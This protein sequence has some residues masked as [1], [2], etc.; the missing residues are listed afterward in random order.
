MSF[1]ILKALGTAGKVVVGF[2]P[3]LGPVLNGASAIADMIGGNAGDKIKSG[4][5]QVTE[6]LGEV[7][8]QPL[9]PEQQIEQQRIA[10]ETKVGLAELGYKEK[11]LDYDDVAG[12]RDVI[13]T[14]LLSDDPIV[15]QARP[16]MMLLLGKTSVGY[17]IGTPILVCIMAW[18]KIDTE[19]LKLITN[20]ILWQGATLWGAFMTSFTGYTISRS[21]DKRSVAKM[22]SG[23]MP[24]N[25]LGLVSKI[26]GKIS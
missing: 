15:R 17:T 11:K 13:K 20:M 3:G 26:G 12:G 14:A 1:D 9:S 19:L 24:S 5:A 8:K 25:L 6:G 7:A 16:K 2:V 23:E 4:I 10:S 22:E 21:A 18:L